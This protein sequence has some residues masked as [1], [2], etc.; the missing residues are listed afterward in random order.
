MS[1]FVKDAISLQGVRV[2]VMDEQTGVF[3]ERELEHIKSKSYDVKYADLP[4]RIVFPTSHDAP[5][6][7]TS[8]T[9]RSYDRTGVA[10]I[11]VGYGTDLPRAD[12]TGTEYS[13]PVKQVGNSYGYTTKEI[14]ESRLVGK[15]LDARRAASAV[16]GNEEKFNDIA[17]FG[18]ADNGLF[19]LFTVGGIPTST[20][21]TKAAGGT[22]WRANATPEEILYDMN[23]AV[24]QMVSTTKMKEKPTRMLVPV[25][26]HQYI[27]STTRATN[28]ASDTTILKY[29]LDN[30]VYI[31]EVLPI[32]ELSGAGT[33]GVDVFVIYNPDPDNLTFEIPMEQKHL[34]PERRGLEWSIACESETGGLNVYYPL[35]LAI[36]EGI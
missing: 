10:K 11:I 26:H 1:K 16:R 27:S 7:S 32:N 28:A 17:W 23:N 4:F 13:V 5:E 18:D 33:G 9:V 21:A 6:G 3:F 36:W 29:F 22:T 31:N 30:N 25:A 34:P 15:S 2:G 14:R 35:S 20:V 8:I 24:A 19:G 12:I